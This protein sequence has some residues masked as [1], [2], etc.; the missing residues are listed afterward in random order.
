MRKY[1]KLDG[2]TKAEV[3]LYVGAEFHDYYKKKWEYLDKKNKKISFNIAS[4]LFLNLWLVYRKMYKWAY[5]LV[6]TTFIIQIITTF[7]PRTVDQMLNGLNIALWVSLVL[8]A[9]Y[10]FEKHAIQEVQKLK[11][12]YPN[13][14]QRVAYLR[15]HG[16]GSSKAVWTLIG[17]VLV[18]API[19]T[20]IQTLLTK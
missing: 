6:A 19:T 3:G 5:G 4:L 12:K 14:N 10:L 15:K 8:T 1:S 17:V 9:N 13:R 16:G 2:L 20:W 11:E 18:L 7:T